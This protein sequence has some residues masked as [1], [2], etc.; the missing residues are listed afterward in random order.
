MP[1]LILIIT[2]FILTAACSSPQPA[3][4]NKQLQTAHLKFIADLDDELDCVVRL[5]FQAPNDSQSIDIINTSVA[6][7]F[8]AGQQLG[9]RSFELSDNQT[10]SFEFSEQFKCDILKINIK[11]NHCLSENQIT[12]CPD[13]KIDGHQSFKKITLHSK[14]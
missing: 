12:D 11:I 13:V 4:D 8:G 7:S 14:R 9:S 6:F 3:N 2:L 1:K 5:N 10:E